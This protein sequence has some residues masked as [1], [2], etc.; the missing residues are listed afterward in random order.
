MAAFAEGGRQALLAKPI[1]GRSRKLGDKEMRTGWRLW[2]ATP[3][4]SSNDS[5]LRCQFALSMF[6][7]IG[8]VIKRVLNIALLCLAAGTACARLAS[9]RS[10]RY[11]A[12]AS[13]TQ[14]WS[15]AGSSRV[16]P[17]LPPRTSVRE[18]VSTLPTSKSVAM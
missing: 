5:S 12:H 3:A 4:R 7:L 13:A 6:S 14:G 2:C 18:R 17:L 16:F 8:E 1:P 11:S 15:S 10:V 9:R